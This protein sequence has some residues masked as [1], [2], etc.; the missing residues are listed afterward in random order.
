MPPSS[1]AF[2]RLL[3]AES[4]AAMP[5]TEKEVDA[6][7]DAYRVRLD[8]D[9]RK[10]KGTNSKP[11]SERLE[12]AAAVLWFHTHVNDPVPALTRLS[13]EMQELLG[14]CF[15][16]DFALFKG[17]SPNWPSKLV[18]FLKFAAPADSTPQRRASCQT[19]RECPAGGGA[20]RWR[21]FWPRGW[22]C[23]QG[24]STLRCS[25]TRS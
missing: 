17:E 16:P 19:G 22:S 8:H 15:V 23:R 25:Y 5:T 6:L 13:F 1:I 18:C 20:F 10:S 11:T 21:L 9:A 12:L 3:R 4:T 2:R 14:E 24:R 7:F